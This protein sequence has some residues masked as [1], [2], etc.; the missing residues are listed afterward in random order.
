MKSH[1]KGRAKTGRSTESSGMGTDVALRTG[2]IVFTLRRQ[3]RIGVLQ[4]N[5]ELQTLCHG[6]QICTSISSNR[7]TFEPYGLIHDSDESALWVA[8]KGNSCLL[9]IA[10]DSAGRVDA[11][12]RFAP[13]GKEQF[14]LG[15]IAPCSLNLCPRR[16]L[17]VSCF[18][19]SI[20][21]GSLVQYYAGT[22]T[23]LVPD[24]FLDRISHASWL[25]KDAFCYV[26]RSDSV[27]WYVEKPGATPIQ[28]T[29]P[30][31]LPQ[32]ASIEIPGALELLYVQGLVY[33]QERRKL[34]LTDAIRNAT[35]SI[36]TSALSRCAKEKGHLVPSD[37]I[38]LCGFNGNNSN[39]RGPARA[40]AFGTCGEEVIALDGGS[41]EIY[42]I[43]QSQAPQ[44]IGKVISDQEPI[45]ILGCG[46]QA[47]DQI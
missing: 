44:Y 47:I 7:R 42:R 11:V 43:Q 30:S 18:G 23:R 21:V 46:I 3:K 27:L 29:T 4:P 24:S 8:D 36:E 45:E 37:V 15:L 26:T 5:Q 10:L 6:D 1:D 12:E 22:W 34:Y 38:D 41:A 9:R 2:S 13:G 33:S 20:Q 31:M 39:W 17:L 16:G 32:T 28:L 35:Y 14:S 19:S 25:E 40:V